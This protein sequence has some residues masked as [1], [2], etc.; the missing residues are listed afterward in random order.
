MTAGEFLPQQQLRLHF[1][2]RAEHL[3]YRAVGHVEI[4]VLA[5]DLHVAELGEQHTHQRRAALD[6]QALGGLLLTEQQAVKMGLKPLFLHRLEEIVQG[7]DTVALV[8]ETGRGGEEHNVGGFIAETDLGGGIEAA[9]AG[10]HNVQQ[11]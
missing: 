10:H 5:V 6:G 4:D 3:V 2:Q 7:A 9:D 8:G 11:I 1:P